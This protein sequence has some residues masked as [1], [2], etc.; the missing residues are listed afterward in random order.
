MTRHAC[1]SRRHAHVSSQTVRTIYRELSRAWGPQHWWPAETPFE[2]IVGAIL[3][4]NTSWTNVERALANLRAANAL[5]V[6]GIRAA[7]LGELEQIVRPSGYFRQKAARLKGFV[8]FLDQQLWRVAGVDARAAH[9][10]NS[11][12]SFWRKKALVQKPRTPSCCMQASTRFLSSMPT[13][14]ECWSATRRLAAR[15]RMTRCAN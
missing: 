9:R 2:V 13:R 7:T 15:L 4:Q 3:T 6:A 1:D 8:A 12:K 11:A 10:S 14:E 5:S